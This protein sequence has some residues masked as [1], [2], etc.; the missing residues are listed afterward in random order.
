MYVHDGKLKKQSSIDTW[1]DFKSKLPENAFEHFREHD[2]ILSVLI[3]IKRCFNITPIKLKTSND[4]DAIYFRELALFLLVHYSN[5][6]HEEIMK[7]FKIK[8]S[9]LKKYQN[10]EYF[11]N[12]YKKEIELYFK[13]KIDDFANNRFSQIHFRD[14]FDIDKLVDIILEKEDK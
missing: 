6:S 3:H 4:K 12:R 1:E 7:E 13:D 2:K 14:G 8:N 10:I 5:A 9:E 11:V